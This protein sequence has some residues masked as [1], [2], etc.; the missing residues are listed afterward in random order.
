MKKITFLTVSLIMLVLTF[1]TG[2]VPADD[3]D[4]DQIVVRVDGLACPFCVYGLEKKVLQMEGVTSF[5][6]DLRLGKVFFDVK[7]GADI[8]P[9]VVRKAVE[10]AGFTPR[11]ISLFTEGRLVK[12]ID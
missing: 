9:T 6:A 1:F 4:V 11:G 12:E 10:D 7:P 2:E 3:N 8:D 5:D